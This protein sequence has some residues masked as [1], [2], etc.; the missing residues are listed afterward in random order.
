MQINSHNTESAI[1]IER[2]MLDEMAIEYGIQDSRVI[3]QSQKLDQ[4]IVDEQKR[5]IPRD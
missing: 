4:L 1:E 3:A 5:R 2:R